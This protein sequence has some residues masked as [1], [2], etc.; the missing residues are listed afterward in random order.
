MTVLVNETH[1]VI[2]GDVCLARPLH[3]LIDGLLVYRHHIIFLFLVII[4]VVAKNNVFGC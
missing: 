4:Y 2:H 3:Q 1:T